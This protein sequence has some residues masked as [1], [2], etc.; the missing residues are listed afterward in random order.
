MRW[1]PS[2]SN[3]LCWIGIGVSCAVLLALLLYMRENETNHTGF[4]PWTLSIVFLPTAILGASYLVRSRRGDARGTFRRL[5]AGLLAVVIGLGGMGL[6]YT[7]DTTNRLLHYD[8][9][10]RR[11]MPD[12]PK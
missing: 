9:W 10:L 3:V 4:E 6:L 8:R 12:L 7:I 5:A 11:G 1:S 2:R